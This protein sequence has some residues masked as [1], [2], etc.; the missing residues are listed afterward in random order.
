MTIDRLL[1]LRGK[2]ALVIGA[3]QG[4]GEAVCLALAGAGCDLVCVDLDPERAEAIAARVR[5]LGQRG[6]ALSGDIAEDSA[7]ARLLADAHGAFGALDVLVTIV[8]SAGFRPLLDMSADQWDE[9]QRINLRY[10]FLAAKTFAA[11]RIEAKGPGAIV[12]VSS[13]SG[14]VAAPRHGAY[15]AAK[16]GL[17]HL[18]KTMASEWGV[19]GIR[20]NSVA[21]GSIVT[22]RLP[23]TAEW[24]EQIERSPLPMQRRGTV[25]EV[26]SA[27][28]FLCS[29][30]A[31][32]VTGQTLAVDGGLAIANV[33]AV[34][35]RLNDRVT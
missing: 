22:P 8:G 12:A 15:G 2:K 29:D 31:A 35:P 26:A 9:D 1:G 7:G 17:V 33:M 20:V 19:H 23:D 4:M 30:M 13:I 24:R 21:P 14:L 6:H 25:D 3:G 11:Q 27:V 34:P 32:Y 16:A 28:L 5:E 18:V 10:V